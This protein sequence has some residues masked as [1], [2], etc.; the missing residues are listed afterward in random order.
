MAMRVAHLVPHGG[1]V[2]GAERVAYDLARGLSSRGHESVLVPITL[3]GPDRST[4]Q[5]GFDRVVGP[6]P[7][8]RVRLRRSGAEVLL[9]HGTELPDWLDVLDAGIPVVAMVHDVSVTCPRT[10]RYLPFSANAC[11]RVA[12]WACWRCAW[13]P[14]R[15]A[16][17][18]LRLTPIRRNARLR[19][20]L[21]ALPRTVVPSR[22]LADLLRRHGWRS[23]SLAVVTPARFGL[24]PPP[25]PPP[26]PGTVLF[27]GALNRG[28]GPD[29]LIAALARLDGW[30]RLDVVGDGSWREPLEKLSRLL[31]IGSRVRFHGRLP[32][33]GVSERY[34]EAQV[35]AFPSRA[36]ESFGLVGLEAMAHG[37]P[38]V[39]YDLGGVREWIVEERTGLLVPVGN[40]DALARALGELL[41]QPERAR[42][43]GEAGRKEW[44]AHHGADRFVGRMERLLQAEL[45]AA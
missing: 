43:L 29:Q 39:A 28:K 5:G 25:A 13:L 32:A 11:D 14:G 23:E 7:D 22:Y 35:V 17:G 37:R 34:R 6:G 8:A 3:S 24:E 21:C 27:V 33:A 36:P 1:F 12:P 41:D 18:R 30:R 16:D 38:V 9:L 15:G 4:Y 20:A 40:V 45:E 42:A 2:G 19:E 26:V 44:L 31:G 10:H